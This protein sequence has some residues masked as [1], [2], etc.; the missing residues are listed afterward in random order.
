MKRKPALLALAG[1]AASSAP[2]SG[3]AA[4]QA[5]ACSAER[6]ESAGDAVRAARSELMALPLEADG[7]PVPPMTSSRIERVKDR[8]RDFVRAQMACAPASPE[9][10]ALAETMAARSSFFTI[11]VPGY[12]ARE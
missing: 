2:G 9:V 5:P 6:V 12:P 3:A 4:A 8:L 1:L 11:S 10:E 7:T